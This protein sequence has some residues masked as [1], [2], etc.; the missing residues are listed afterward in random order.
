MSKNICKDDIPVISIIVPIYNVERWLSRCL[1]S[2]QDQTFNK[3]ECLLINDGSTD[4]SIKIA[5]KFE[6]DDSRFKIFNK[7]NGGLSD[8][9]NYGIVRAKGR[10]I[11]FIDSDDFVEKKYLELLINEIMKN[12]AQIAIC[13]FYITDEDGNKLS[14]VNPNEAKNI[15]TGKDALHYVFKQNGY[16]N[17]VAWNKI[18]QKNLFDDIKFEKGRFYED[19]YINFLL[20]WKVNKICLLNKP[21]YNYVQRNG[22]IVNTKMTPQKIK[23][24]ND[25]LV[26]RISFYQGKNQELYSYAIQAYKNWIISLNQENAKKI[27]FEYNTYL[28]RQF[29]KMVHLDNA[30][31]LALK[32]QD[33]LGY[34][35]IKMAAKIKNV[36]LGN[37]RRNQ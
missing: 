30:T 2:I 19:E 31:S 3:Y 15:V 34:I 6:Q 16:V 32:I 21:L 20:F 33:I 27:P 12:K 29:K 26:K 35:N 28:Q 7:K 17:V 9:R 8:A 10:Y 14:E 4:E 13:G 23:D 37:K 18:Y 22:S 24:K 25:M 11:V 36:L 1:S 5:Q